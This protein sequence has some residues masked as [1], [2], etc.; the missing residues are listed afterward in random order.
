[1]AQ[2]GIQDSCDKDIEMV[3]LAYYFRMDKVND[4]TEMCH[5][6]VPLPYR[7]FM[8]ST[9]QLLV[10]RVATV[11]EPFCGSSSWHRLSAHFLAW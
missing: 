7:C 3:L 11:S 5:L 8:N 2:H 9:E 4:M 10:P 1:L 6:V